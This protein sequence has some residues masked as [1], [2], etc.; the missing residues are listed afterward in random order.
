MSG[1][2]HAQ[3]GANVLNAHPGDGKAET[4]IWLI[5][6][7]DGPAFQLKRPNAT[8]HIYVFSSVFP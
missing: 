8:P 1:N 6:P 7:V 2:L 5:K 4:L 3:K